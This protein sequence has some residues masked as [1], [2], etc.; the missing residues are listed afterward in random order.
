MDMAERAKT[1]KR[2]AGVQR[3]KGGRVDGAGGMGFM[4]LVWTK[5]CREGSKWVEVFE[6]ELGG[7]LVLVRKWFEWEAFLVF[8]FHA[9]DAWGNE[10][11]PPC[12]PPL[13]PFR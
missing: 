2:P 11:V 4:I 3:R 10:Y 5:G 6:R 7:K 1:M 12:N 8:V 13:N 9:A